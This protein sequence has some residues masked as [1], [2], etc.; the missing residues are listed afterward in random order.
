MGKAICDPVTFLGV[1]ASNIDS[2]RE[3]ILAGTI[4]PN[5]DVAYTYMTP[6]S[7]DD[8]VIQPAIQYAI[9]QKNSLP[10][11]YLDALLMSPLHSINVN[12]KDSTGATIVESMILANFPPN[13]I[14]E[15]IAALTT[16]INSIGYSPTDEDVD[17]V[18]SSSL[19][20]VFLRVMV[21]R[22]TADQLRNQITPIVTQGM[23]QSLS[24][25]LD[26]GIDPKGT[27]AYHAAI[28]AQNVAA[29][30]ILLAQCCEMA[31]CLDDVVDQQ[32]KTARQ[33]TA[34]SSI[35]DQLLTSIR[36]DFQTPRGCL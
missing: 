20:D 13:E 23:L 8:T 4:D 24:A 32:N 2:F 26:L 14:N 9:R 31:P 12:E 15:V 30:N 5:C 7:V 35:S 11:G 3:D 16:P 36:D 17:L 25:I 22:L 27:L 29:F 6:T 10:S 34:A 28:N 1:T 33:L 18:V 19:D 21:P